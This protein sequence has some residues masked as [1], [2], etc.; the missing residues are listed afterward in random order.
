[1]FFPTAEMAQPSID[2]CDQGELKFIEDAGHWVL[3]EAPDSVN[4]LVHDFLAKA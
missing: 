3:R 4:R 2:L 1:M